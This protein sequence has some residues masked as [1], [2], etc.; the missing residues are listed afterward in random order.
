MV[1]HRRDPEDTAVDDDDYQRDLA[2][3]I[4]SSTRLREIGEQVDEAQRA[5]ITAAVDYA[6]AEADKAAQR[7]ST[8][9]SRRGYLVSVVVAAILALAVSLPF[10]VVG[11]VK[12]QDAAAD[13]SALRAGDA[14]SSEVSSARE[15]SLLVVRRDFTNANNALV[16]AGLT[17][18][19]EPPA[20]ASAYQV[21]IATGEALGTLRS[22]GELEK[23]GQAIPGVSAP[24]PGSAGFPGP[25]R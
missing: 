22:L 20:D 21:A 12:G 10:A 7:R 9:I 23:R 25:G 6:V 4:A 18:V 5:A 19:A 24:D 11:Y 8:R 3:L 14:A 15:S 16:A 1:N 13:A 2:D 17:P